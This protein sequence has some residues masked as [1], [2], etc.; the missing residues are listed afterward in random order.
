M[1]YDPSSGH[2]KYDTALISGELFAGCLDVAKEV[3]VLSVFL[4][5]RHL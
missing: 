1:N 3:I 4:D 5:L 2:Y